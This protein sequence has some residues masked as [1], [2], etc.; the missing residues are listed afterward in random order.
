MAAAYNDGS[1]PYGSQVL[2]INSVNYVAEQID[3]SRPTK[4]IKRYNAVGEPV[5]GRLV[6][7]LNGCKEEP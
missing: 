6:P 4:K 1:L 2:N 3:V 5:S 7:A